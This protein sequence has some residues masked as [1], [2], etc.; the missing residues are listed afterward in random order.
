MNPICL[1]AGQ[2]LPPSM[3]LS[4]PLCALAALSVMAIVGLVRRLSSPLRKVP[5]PPWSLLTSL[6]LRWNALNAGRTA[7]IHN[8]HRRYGPVVRIAPNEVSFT[9]WPALKEIYCSGGSGY[10]K[11]S[12]YDLF[13]VYGR[14]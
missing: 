10:D 12:F 3:L 8:L 11:S 7:Y 2:K 4:L 6:V 9:P 1:E 5:G 13:K 14:R